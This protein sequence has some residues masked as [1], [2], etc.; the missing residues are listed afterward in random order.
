MVTIL[1]EDGHVQSVYLHMDEVNVT[2]GQ[3]VEMS[4]V[5]GTIGETGN[6]MCRGGGH[7]HYEIKIDGTLVDPQ[8]AI[9]KPI[10]SLSRK[11]AFI[12]NLIDELEKLSSKETRRNK[13]RKLAEDV[14]PERK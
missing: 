3:D 5:I 13:L 1:H 9:G 4:T 2:V 10:G 7:L 8:K 6:A 14:K 11:S 12:K